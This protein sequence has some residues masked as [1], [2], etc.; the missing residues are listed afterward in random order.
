MAKKR[1][2][3]IFDTTLR[4]GEQSPGCSMNLAEKLEVA[5]ALEALKVDI[6]EAG[7]PIASPGDFEAVQAISA[8]IRNCTIA[9]LARAV[10]KDIE[11]AGEAVAG[12]ARPR[13][14]VFCATSSIH[15]QY[16]LKR[17]KEEILRMSVEGVKLAKQY[18]DDVEFSP[19][20]ASRTE[21]EFLVEVVAAVIEAGA[22]TVNIPDTVGYAIPS[23]FGQVIAHLREH[24][25]NIDDAVISVHCHNDLGLAV[26]NS[27]AA[28]AAGAGQV[29]CTING[30]GERAGNAALEE[31][32]MALKTRTDLFSADTGIETSRIYPTSRLVSGI[33]GVHVQRNKAIVGENAFAHEAGVHQHG[34]L[35]NRETYEIMN[36]KAIGVPASKLVLGKHSG[37]HAL[38]ERI[39]AL[40]YQLDEQQLREVF[41]KFKVLA[42]K[43][44][45]VYDEDIEG[46]IDQQL[47]AAAE[48]WRLRDL[49][50]TAGTNAIPTAT[51]TLCKE[52]ECFT[53]AATGDGPVDAIYEAIGRITGVKLELTEYSLRALTGGKEAQGEVT[54]EVDHE[55]TKFRARG[56]ST[57]IV[58][59]SARAYLSAVNRVLT[60]ANGRE[61][62]EQP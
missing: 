47:G 17:A 19:E 16:K 6:I 42:D 31:L 59:A 56:L 60:A 14:H 34:M 40:G 27:L 46:L 8:E 54:I 9:G 58:E 33:T 53:D 62:I 41:E 12:A 51:I 3:L 57:D 45:D 20:D 25:P 52:D 11:R 35:S 7:F 29:E 28:V 49:Q 15:R 26:A 30:L 39:E 23:E 50:T 21:P 1:N 24:V 32:V 61:E 43:K 4:D 2:I 18:T 22:T 10:D 38:S 44:K 37:R 36:P 48:V 13:V 55:G 5:H